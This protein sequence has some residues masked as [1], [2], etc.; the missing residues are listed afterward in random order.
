MFAW[1]SAGSPSVP[2]RYGPATRIINERRAASLTS[3]PRFELLSYLA[4]HSAE[5]GGSA[6]QAQRTDHFGQRETGRHVAGNA[7]H[8]VGKQAV[9]P[10]VED[11]G[12]AACGRRLGR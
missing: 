6:A 11:A 12:E 2:E 5:Q 10:R 3:S 7:E 1:M 8:L 4:L 9:E